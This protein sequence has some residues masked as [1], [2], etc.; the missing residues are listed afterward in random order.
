MQLAVWLKTDEPNLAIYHADM[1][2]TSTSRIPA[3]LS[4]AASQYFEGP[5]GHWSS[6]VVRAGTPEQ[7]F[8]VLPSTITSETFVPLAGACKEGSPVCNYL[9]YFI[10]GSSY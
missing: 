8:R 6:F 9:S 3:P 1:S 5:D 7:S 10:F 4:F 2:N